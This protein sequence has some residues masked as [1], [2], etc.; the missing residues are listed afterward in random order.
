MNIYCPNCENACSDKA[1]A[2]PKCGHP[3]QAQPAPIQRVQATPIHQEPTQ[4]Q[5]IQIP[6]S[7]P[8]PSVPISYPPPSVRKRGVPL[9][10][11]CG[12]IMK[13]TSVSNNGCSL[14]LAGLFLIFTGFGLWLTFIGAI[15]GMLIAVFG[16]ILMSTKKVLKCKSCGSIVQRA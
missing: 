1:P 7:Y 13:K 15:P 5:P 11:N 10:Q 14:Q 8:P 12:G 16:A 3:F 9:C 4:V 2:C 6:I